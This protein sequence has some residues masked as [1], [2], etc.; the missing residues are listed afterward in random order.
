MGRSTVVNVDLRCYI[1]S[2]VHS[3]APWELDFG[4]GDLGSETLNQRHHRVVKQVAEAAARA[5]RDP[6]RV[7]LV[8]VTKHASLEAMRAV[9]AL[10]LHR[11]GESKVQDALPKMAELAPLAPEWHFIGHL[12][13]NKVKR[14]VGAFSLIHSVDSWRLAEAISD[15]GCSRGL[16][17]PILVQVNT[18]GEPSKHGLSPE[19]APVVIERM[20]RELPGVEVRGLMTMA[21]RSDDPEEARG[22]F[23]KCRELLEQLATTLPRGHRLD[24]LSMGMSQDYTVAVEEGATLIRVGSG[25]FL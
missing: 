2:V 16:V 3:K 20:A 15:E 8:A 10:G 6:S 19:E 12:Q 1:Y 23:R 24:Q 17:Q 25:L 21:P 5:G 7:A 13:T 22:C 4:K 11:F 18:S 9:V 14:V